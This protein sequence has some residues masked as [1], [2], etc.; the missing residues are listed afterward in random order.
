MY[1]NNMPMPVV[2]STMAGMLKQVSSSL[3][4]FSCS[5]L[6]AACL[7]FTLPT[8]AH[9]FS[10]TNLQLLYGSSFNDNYYGNNT[11]DG[12]MTTLTLEHFSTWAYG[13][14][15]FFV[16]FLSGNFLDFTGAP[17]GSK[18]RIY[19][20]W[21]PRLSLSAITGHDLSAGMIKDLFIAAQ[22]NRDGEG[23][24]AEMIGLGVDCSMPGFNVL[25]LHAYLRKDNLNRKTWQS[26]GVWNIPLGEWLSFE[27]FIDLYGTDNNGMELHTQPQLLVNIGKLTAEDFDNLSVGLEY[28]YHHNSNLDSSAL[29]GMLKWVW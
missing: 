8:Q 12:K 29:Q 11:S 17:S 19:S 6:A 25:S 28:Y 26:T 15:Y 16:D 21:A 4:V 18:S 22:L 7:C 14:N 23:F 2:P 20:E 27:G 13:D 9:A 24:H 10:S 3:H 1:Y 5:M